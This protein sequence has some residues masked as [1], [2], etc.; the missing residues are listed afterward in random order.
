LEP[1]AKNNQKNSWKNT[2]KYIEVRRRHR[3]AQKMV[4]DWL[5]KFKN[6]KIKI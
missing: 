4:K 2:K 6:I 1:Q 5:R 3:D